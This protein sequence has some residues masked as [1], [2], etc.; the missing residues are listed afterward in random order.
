MFLLRISTDTIKLEVE[1]FII[2]KTEY[3]ESRGDNVRCHL[4]KK[5][6]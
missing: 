4:R 3:G 6:G 2:K 5:R 1:F